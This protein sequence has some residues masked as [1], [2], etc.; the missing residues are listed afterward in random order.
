[1]KH[2]TA[3]VVL[4][5]GLQWEG[6]AAGAEDTQG[7]VRPSRL[8]G[9]PL[10]WHPGFGHQLPWPAHAMGLHASYRELIGGVVE[11]HC[12]LKELRGV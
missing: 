1:M 2:H 10:D 12:Y 9:G 6:A 11:T 4:V 8:G 5:G 7:V 3:K